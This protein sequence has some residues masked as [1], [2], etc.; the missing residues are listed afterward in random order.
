MQKQ[1]TTNKQQYEQTS[2]NEYKNNMRHKK[3]LM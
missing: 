3:E 2:K 1:L